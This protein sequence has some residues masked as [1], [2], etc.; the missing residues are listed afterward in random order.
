M[1]DIQ[2]VT[3]D[4]VQSVTPSDGTDQYSQPASGFM[5]TGAGT[6]TLITARNTTIQITCLAGLIYPIAFRRIKSTG[7]AATGIAALIASPYKG[8][9]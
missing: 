3:Y 2:A 5:V 4:D 9:P 1:S 6:V 8:L 7:T